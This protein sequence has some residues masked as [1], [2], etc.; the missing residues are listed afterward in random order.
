VR[1]LIALLGVVLLTIMLAEV[2]D[3]V[4][5]QPAREAAV[6]QEGF[7]AGRINAPPEVCP[8]HD[9]DGERAWKRGWVEGRKA[10]LGGRAP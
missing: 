5:R 9:F 6:R 4:S 1:G 2:W 7:E 8:F 10:A 3:A